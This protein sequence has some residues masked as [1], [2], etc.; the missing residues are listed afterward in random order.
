VEAPLGIG[1]DDAVQDAAVGAVH[2]ELTMNDPEGD[3]KALLQ[4]YATALSPHYCRACPDAACVE[5]CPEDIVIPTVLRAVMYE[6]HYRWPE[7]A[8]ET[9]RA[10]E[11]ANWS[12][13]C[14]TCDQ[15][16]SACPHGVDASARI[17]DAR[18]VLG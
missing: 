11:G 9:Y 7:Q 6:R 10:F 2:D 1:T 15:C 18:R 8:R 3:D 12:D 17:R 4:R 13:R 16:D 5:A 14:H